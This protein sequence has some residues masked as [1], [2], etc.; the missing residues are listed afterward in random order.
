MTFPL[1]I[2]SI[3]ISG[4]VLNHHLI[5]RNEDLTFSW[6]A[7]AFRQ[8]VRSGHISS[9]KP[10]VTSAREVDFDSETNDCGLCGRSGNEL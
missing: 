3:L 6:L 5:A 10:Q 1:K 7:A 4:P 2:I 8:G 9:S